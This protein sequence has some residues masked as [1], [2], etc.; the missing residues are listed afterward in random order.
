MDE[1]VLKGMLSG[2]AVIVCIGNELRGDDGV[3][4]FVSGLIKA[5][6]KVTVINCG[7]TPEN[8]LGVISRLN[9]QKVVIID[10]ANFGGQPGQIRTVSRSEITGGGLSTHD[11]VLTLFSGY[12]EEQTGA[13]TF[14]VAIQPGP[15]E[16]GGRLSVRVEQAAIRLAGLINQV[17][18]EQESDPELP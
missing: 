12:I 17:I 9:P 5:S 1:S 6:R 15:T 16:V 18:Q 10:A 8:Y 11:A 2:R 13:E 7:E 4:P 14:F 3:G